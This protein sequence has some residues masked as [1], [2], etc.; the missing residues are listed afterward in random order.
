[1]KLNFEQERLL[2]VVAHPDDAELLCAGTL[3]R[4]RHEGAAIGI[5]VLCQGDKGQPE[6]PIHNLAEVRQQ[7]MQSAAKLLGADLFF[8]ENPDGALFDSLEQRRQLTEIMRQFSPTLVLAH[9]QS[10]YHADHRAA[11]V[12]T[13]AA[14][15][16]SASVGNQTQSPALKQPPALWWMDTVNMTQ[17]EPYFYIDVSQYVDTKLAML[18]CHQSQLQRGKDTSFSP[19]RDLMLQ[20][21]AARGAQ[22]SVSSAEAFQ[23]HTAWKRC[24]AW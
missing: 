9:S 5:C 20:Q 14:T 6:P 22:S 19:L 24:A 8:G 1:M 7:E 3:A 13:E 21:C 2:A 12:I 23:S 11:S 15:W 10:D 4:A 18:D 16:F 17:F